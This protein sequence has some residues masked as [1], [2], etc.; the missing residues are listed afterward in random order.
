MC[1]SSEKESSPCRE[2]D[3]VCVGAQIATSDSD[4]VYGAVG[5]SLAFILLCAVVYMYSKSKGG[6][7]DAHA[8]TAFENPLCT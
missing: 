6:N 7:D 2:N 4:A 8:K 1:N 5:G 3:R